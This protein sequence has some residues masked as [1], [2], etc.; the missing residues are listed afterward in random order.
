[1]TLID[2]REVYYEQEKKRKTFKSII[3][4][5]IVLTIIAIILLLFIKI[6]DYGKLRIYVDGEE[7]SNI[8]DIILLKDNNGKLVEKDGKLYFSV[9][10]M[11]NLLK[12]QYYNSEIKMSIH[13]LFLIHQTYT[14]L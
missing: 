2:E 5:I 9:R 7:I 10:D 3:T 4:A 11:S 13:L 14:N 1:M 6:R 8:E 12:R